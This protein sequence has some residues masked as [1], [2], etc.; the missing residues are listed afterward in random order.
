MQ[1][2]L[3]ECNVDLSSA[4]VRFLLREISRLI[5]TL[6]PFF[7]GYNCAVNARTTGGPFILP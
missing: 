3:L 7:R 2:A 1:K 5:I 4:V 6:P